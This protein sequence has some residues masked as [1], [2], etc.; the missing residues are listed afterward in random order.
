MR[1]KMNTS[2]KNR[3][4]NLIVEAA[5]IFPIFIISVLVLIQIIPV[6]RESE[7]ILFATADEVRLEQGKS[8]FRKSDTALPAAVSL[9]VS[10][11]NNK[12]RVIFYV[13]SYRYMYTKS[14]IKDLFSIDS[15][16]VF[17]VGN[18][19]GI[20]GKA[21]FQAKITARAFTGAETVRTSGS[22]PGD[23]D[24]DEAVCIFP[25]HGT[26]YHDPDCT[27]V[28]AECELTVLSQDIKRRFHPCPECNAKAA[29][30][31]SQVFLFRDSGRAYHTE[32]CRYIDRYYVTVGKREAIEKGYTP[33]SKCGG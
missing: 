18:R 1:S 27:Y 25:E 11:E 8:A 32:G 14:G 33:C 16:S 9:R 24:D 28:K 29:G 4:G 21:S 19:T 3:K 10:G 30:T 6:I 7:N 2:L 23:T 15:K 13:R 31:G 22:G 17:N 26:K 12:P 5:V 20:S